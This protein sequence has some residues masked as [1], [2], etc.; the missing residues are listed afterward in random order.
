MHWYGHDKITKYYSIGFTE[1][2]LQEIE[3][4][5]K[6]AKIGRFYLSKYAYFRK[7]T[8]FI[9]YLAMTCIDLE[10]ENQQLK[11]AIRETQAQPE[12]MGQSEE[13]ELTDA[14]TGYH[15]GIKKKEN[16]IY[17]EWG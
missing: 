1:K 6:E 17:P 9:R 2:E 12:A 13:T 14:W 10:K 5:Y 4:A 15:R 11:K 3:A 7:R 16:V 8:N